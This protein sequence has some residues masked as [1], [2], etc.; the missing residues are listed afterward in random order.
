MRKWWRVIFNNILE[1][2]VVNSFLVYKK[3]LKHNIGYKKFKLMIIHE[4]LGKDYLK[5][6][7]GKNQEAFNTNGLADHYPE[8]M[9]HCKVCRVCGING[10]RRQSSYSCKACS[11]AYQKP[12]HLCIVPCFEEFHTNMQKYLSKKP[13]TWKRKNGEAEFEDDLLAKESK[14]SEEKEI[15][16]TGLPGEETTT[17]KRKR[18]RRTKEEILLGLNAGEGRGRKEKEEAKNETNGETTTTKK[19]K[20]RRKK[21]KTDEGSKGGEDGSKIVEED[22]SKEPEIFISE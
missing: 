19:R 1:I 15:E 20:Y 10:P 9:E 6:L 4:L 13:R 21:T 16:K 12:I 3:F 7:E 11:R 5:D 18:K 2:S 14:E 17:T 8:K 22:D